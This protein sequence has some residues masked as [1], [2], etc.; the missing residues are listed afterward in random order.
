[1]TLGTAEPVVTVDP[2]VRAGRPLGQL[3]PG[4]QA[5]VISIAAEDEFTR[6]LMDLGLTPGTPVLVVR[7]APLG[8]PIE[9]FVRGCH[10]SIRREEANRILVEAL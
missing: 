9:V 3:P 7:C 6:P 8:D 4:T 10:F 1:M 5:V 2:A